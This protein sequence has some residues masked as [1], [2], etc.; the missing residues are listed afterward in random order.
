MEQVND[1]DLSG[2]NESHYSRMD[3]MIFLSVCV[4]YTICFFLISHLSF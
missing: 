1:F 3:T 2:P 4:F